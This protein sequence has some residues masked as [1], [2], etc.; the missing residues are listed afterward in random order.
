MATNISTIR[1]E[2]R[3]RVGNRSTTALPESRLDFCIR[4][5]VFQISSPK[6]HKQADLERLIDLDTSNGVDTYSLG[7][8]DQIW[9]IFS[10]RDRTTG[11][12]RRLS[13]IGPQAMDEIEK[14]TGIPLRYA[15]WGGDAGATGLEIDPIPNGVYN[16]RARVYTYP[17]FTLDSDGLLTGTLPLRPVYDEGILLGAEYRVWMNILQN[18]TRGAVVKNQLS[19]WIDTIISPAEG[20]L[21]DNAVDMLMPN[22]RGVYG[23]Y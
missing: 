5:S 14:T 16:L 13:N 9:T 17:S 2:L 23:S 22:I 6:V 12:I 18:P 19:D 10:L 7:T 20:E 8:A 21:D 1:A 4:E 3:S 15:R 11:N